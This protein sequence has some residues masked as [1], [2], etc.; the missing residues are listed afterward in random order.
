MKFLLNN[1]K[2]IINSGMFKGIY[3]LL[4]PKYCVR[5]AIL[6]SDRNYPIANVL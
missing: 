4:L 2:K 3:R 1:A 6:V 5:H